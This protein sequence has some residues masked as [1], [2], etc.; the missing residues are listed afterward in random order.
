MNSSD[1]LSM[2]ADLF[3]NK[4][5]QDGNGLDANDISHALSGL[6]GNDKGELN[7]GG[8][9][10]KMNGSGLMDVAQSWLGDGDNAKI[11][12]KQ[13]NE[14]FDNDAIS[15]FAEK[16]GIGEDQARDTLGETMPKMVD[17]SSQGGSLLDSVGGISGAVNLASR[18]FSR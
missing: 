18:F 2:G 13:V 16:L 1:L 15:I 5:D 10:E 17:K 7:L 8:L 6:L 12:S 14:M 4:L 11:E 9:I 3:K